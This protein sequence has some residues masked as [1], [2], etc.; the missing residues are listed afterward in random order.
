MNNSD[1]SES[2]YFPRITVQE[3]GTPRIIL[4]NQKADIIDQWQVGKTRPQQGPKSGGYKRSERPESWSP[5]SQFILNSPRWETVWRKRRKGGEPYF[6]SRFILILEEEGRGSWGAEHVP[7]LSPR[8]DRK[9]LGS[10]RR[11]R[12]GTLWPKYL[13]AF[14]CPKYLE[15]TFEDVIINGWNLYTNNIR[16]RP[17][18]YK[19]IWRRWIWRRRRRRRGGR[20]PNFIHGDS[21]S[22]CS[23]IAMRIYKKNG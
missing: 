8:R 9:A 1:Q 4:T 3:T 21:G 14:H 12:D 23:Q 17:L 18:K 16:T 22:C 13:R 2:C 6:R 10:G 15:V 19:K 5:K 20:N 7:D 11:H